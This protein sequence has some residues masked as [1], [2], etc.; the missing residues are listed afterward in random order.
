MEGDD[1]GNITDTMKN[2]LLVLKNPHGYVSKPAGAGV[3]ERQL[4]DHVVLEP[5]TASRPFVL[6]NKI[7]GG[8]MCGL[9]ERVCEA[10]QLVPCRCG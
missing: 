4:R 2:V 7:I 1:P 5:A 3:E 6:S 9:I 10:F 8:L